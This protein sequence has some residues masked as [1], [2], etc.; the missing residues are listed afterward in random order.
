M[1]SLLG[2]GLSLVCAFLWTSTEAAESP[3]RTQP[4]IW[5]YVNQEGLHKATVADIAG[6][7]QVQCK[8]GGV[9]LVLLVNSEGPLPGLQ[10]ET[11]E[12]AEIRFESQ[13]FPIVLSF[14]PTYSKA[15]DPVHTSVFLVSSQGRGMA[16]LQAIKEGHAF[17]I[18][19]G[20]SV[21]AFSARGSHS[22]IGQL[23]RNC[24]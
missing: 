17:L 2:V 7:F 14:Q 6:F 15:G 5:S 16:I 4:G 3:S 24:G 10:T 9:S 8:A 23:E 11:E 1:R 22:A 21:S 12:A 13:A 19:R 20:E 18:D